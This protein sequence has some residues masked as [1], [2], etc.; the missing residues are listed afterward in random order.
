MSLTST[1]IDVLR[2]WY[3]GAARLPVESVTLT[4]T[5]RLTAGDMSQATLSYVVSLGRN[6]EYSVQAVYTGSPV[7]TLS[8]Q[9]SNDNVTYT[10]LAGLDVNI[11]SAGNTLYNLSGQNYLHYK[12]L[13]TKS[14]GTGSLTVID[15]IK[16]VT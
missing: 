12:L 9:G 15:T 16:G 4:T 13:Y 6:T 2:E 8:I 7:G 11:T 14:S 3:T 10:S 1:V 5:T